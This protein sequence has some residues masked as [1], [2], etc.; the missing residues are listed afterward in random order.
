MFTKSD[1]PDIFS[2]SNFG[3]PPRIYID[4]KNCVPSSIL[5]VGVDGGGG[6]RAMSDDDNDGD[7]S[8]MD[9]ILF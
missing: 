8:D 5:F 2:Y 3:Q 7:D 1:I 4:F 6:V 9:K